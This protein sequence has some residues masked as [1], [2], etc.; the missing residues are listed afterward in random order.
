ML[1]HLTKIAFG[2]KSYADIESWFAGRPRL[3]VNTRYRPTR[4]EECTGG[5]LFWI[6]EHNLVARSPILGFTQQDNGRWFIDLAPTLIPVVA[7]SRRAHQGWRYLADDK[8]PR[9][10]APGEN[11]GDIIPGRLAARLLRLGLI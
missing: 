8:A 3:S 6:H 7:T 11:P 1:L 2:A 10:L 9:D 5:S 4:W